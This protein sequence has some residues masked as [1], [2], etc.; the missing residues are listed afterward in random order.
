MNQHILHELYTYQVYYREDFKQAN[1]GLRPVLAKINPKW[2]DPK[3]FDKYIDDIGEE[4][5][6]N[7]SLAPF[8]I[9]IAQKPVSS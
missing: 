9:N 1:A 6:K 7:K 3:E 5:K 4:A 8:Y 2:E